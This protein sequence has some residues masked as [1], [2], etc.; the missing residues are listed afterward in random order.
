[1]DLNNPLVESLIS[2][3]L[4]EDIA[5]GDITS[6]AC[7]DSQMEASAYLLARESF[8]V[9][10]HDIAREIFFRLDSGL[11]YIIEKADGV[12]VENGQVIARIHGNYRAILTAER[13]ALNFM[14]RLSGVASAAR[15]AS[16]LVKDLDVC[17]V[18]TRKTTPGWRALEKAAVS[19]G[20]ASNHRRGLYDAFLIKN[21]HI[22]AMG[23][24][25]EKAIE[26]CRKSADSETFL[27]VEVR[28]FDE[29]DKALS[30]QVDSILLDNMSTE[31]M[32]RAVMIV[33]QRFPINAPLLEA[34]GGITLESVREI[35]ETGVDRIS[36]GSLTH[37]AKSVDISLRFDAQA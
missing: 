23:G 18:D 13:T 29:L 7:I 24:A 21:N 37:S 31:D 33:A 3:A 11:Q 2:I 6:I 20:G 17:I 10:G 12:Q 5:S 36:M 1:M 30:L 35:A 34:S 14:Q 15:E 27:Q 32:A 8:V 19:I 16:S 4:E 22:D 28:S 9:C 26:Q 25:I